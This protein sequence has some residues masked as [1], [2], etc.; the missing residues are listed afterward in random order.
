VEAYLRETLTRE[1]W[2]CFCNQIPKDRMTT[3]IDLVEAAKRRWKD[4][5]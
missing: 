1:A 3:L 5:E 4:S 2:E